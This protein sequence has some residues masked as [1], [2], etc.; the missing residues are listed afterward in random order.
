V[1]DSNHADRETIWNLV[2]HVAG[3]YRNSGFGLSIVSWLPTHD[4]TRLKFLSRD[5]QRR[6]RT[7]SLHCQGCPDT[8]G[9][10][11]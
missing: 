6:S 5:P 10:D 8:G 2:K 11:L 7:R 3:I 1:L 9:Q 4:K